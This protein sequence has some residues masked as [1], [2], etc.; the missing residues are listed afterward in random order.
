[1]PATAA[2]P[3]PR[4]AQSLDDF[5]VAA[6]ATAITADGDGK[7]ILTFASYADMTKVSAAS[8]I[9]L[10]A[11][12]AP[13][14]TL[15]VKPSAAM[16]TKLPGSSVTAQGFTPV[17]FA[18]VGATLDVAVDAVEVSASTTGATYVVAFT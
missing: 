1:M 13:P 4:P 6:A 7:K 11:G 12:G 2:T 8:S 16:T 10:S 9:M 14:Y 17:V 18:A 3:I 15:Y 5:T